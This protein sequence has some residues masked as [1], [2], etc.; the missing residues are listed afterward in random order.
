MRELFPIKLLL[1]LFQ[2]TSEE[3]AAIER[4]LGGQALPD[5]PQGASG[6]S[7]RRALASESLTVDAS[8][9]SGYLF[10]RVGKLW[11]VVFAGGERFFL[12]NT[13]GTR[14]L[15]YLLHH[16]NDP[17]SAFNLEVAIEPEKGEA[18]SSTSIQQRLD[19]RAQREYRQALISLRADRHHAQAA[20]DRGE[21]SRLD[22]EIAAVES[23][24]NERGGSDDTGERARGN[25]RKA[26]NVI[27]RG[28]LEGGP[29]ERAF[30]EHIRERVSTGYTCLYSQP[31]GRIWA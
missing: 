18:R 17:I 14:Y 7:P 19:A 15:D 2:A 29:N 16:P 30:A 6:L 22:G 11:E 26:I 1:W 8:T 9:S 4:F 23:A 21:V 10:R 20:G 12:E 13:L 27:V 3:L 25:V 5:W 28:L 31:Q 24:L